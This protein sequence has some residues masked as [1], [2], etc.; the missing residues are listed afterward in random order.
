MSPAARLSVQLPTF[1]F[2][3]GLLASHATSK[4][5]NEST[6]TV[7]LMMAS[8]PLAD[9]ICVAKLSAKLVDLRPSITLTG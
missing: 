4:S 5:L 2:D 9:W 7:P 6:L 3:G 1:P 8:R